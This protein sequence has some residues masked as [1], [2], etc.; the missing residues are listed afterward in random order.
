MCACVSV[1]VRVRVRVRVCV[2]V[3]VRVYQFGAPSRCQ[4]FVGGRAAGG[5]RTVMHFD[6]YDNIFMQLAGRKTFLL[7]DPL[8]T[9]R[10]APY[11]VRS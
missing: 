6:Q 9:G 11:P 5:A 7:F 4:L 3:C 1:R 10:L 2:C 8:Q